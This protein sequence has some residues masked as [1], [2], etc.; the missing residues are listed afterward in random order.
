ME[1]EEE[2]AGPDPR[3]AVCTFDRCWPWPSRPS[4]RQIA[5]SVLA[6]VHVTDRK[7]PIYILSQT[8]RPP[9]PSASSA[10][11]AALLTG[12]LLHSEVDK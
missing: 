6:G 12:R 7:T 9:V 8:L 4:V 11:S 1:E 5:V 10:S 3:L 2:E